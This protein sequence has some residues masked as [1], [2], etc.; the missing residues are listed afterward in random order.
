MTKR[1]LW[2]PVAL[3][4]LAGLS[5]GLYQVLQPPSLPAGLLYGNGHIEGTE[6]TVSAE[7]G[8]TVVENR[9]TEGQPVQQ[10]DLLVRLDAADL[11]IQ[12]AQTEAQVAAVRRSEAALKEQLDLWRHHLSTARS[13]LDRFRELRQRGTISPQQLNQAEDRFREA[14]GRVGM[15][16]AQIAEARAQIT[17]AEQQ[18]ALLQQQL[19]KTEIH[20]PISGTV[21]TKAVEAGELATP[22]RAVAVLV[23]LSRLELEIYIPE[24]DIGKVKL[25]DPARVRVDA[26]PDRYFEATVSRVDQRAQFTP[27]DVHM[28]DER[29]RLV[30]GVVI[31]VDNPEGYLK[32]GMPADTWVRWKPE[33]SW[34][35]KLTVPR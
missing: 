2:T 30:F 10:G 12:V 25:G 33:V 9:L 1:W 15:L 18:A 24:G 29:A 21:Q 5:Y 19:D 8:G 32:P 35:D 31:A 20:A 26:F 14:Q 11:R 27:K 23:D 17:A 6:V 3:I 22:G 34:P 13:D 4:A 16:Q 7:V 28:P